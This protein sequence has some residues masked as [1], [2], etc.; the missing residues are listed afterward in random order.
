MFGLRG[1]NISY[2]YTPPGGTAAVP[3]GTATYHFLNIPIT[4]RTIEFIGVAFIIFV[5]A[6]HWGRFVND[7][8]K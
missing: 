8:T 5:L 4:F 1:G 2:P 7:V 6:R 3:V